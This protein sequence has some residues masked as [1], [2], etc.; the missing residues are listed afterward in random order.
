MNGILEK[1]CGRCPTLD[2]ESG[3]HASMDVICH[4]TMQQPGS[5]SA[6]HHFYRL[7]N[8]GEELEDVG[9]VHSV[10]LHAHKESRADKGI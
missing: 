5:R 2:G 1:R 6:R 7:E 9:A 3:L 8:P 4:V 10:C